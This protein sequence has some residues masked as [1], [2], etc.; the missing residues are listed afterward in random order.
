MRRRD[1]GKGIAGLVAAWP[2]SARAQQSAMPVIGFLSVAL[3]DGYRLRQALQGSGFIEGQN[4]AIE[5]RWIMKLSKRDLL[6]AAAVFAAAAGSPS[7]AQQPQK[8]Q[9][10]TSP[11][12][13]DSA[14]IRSGKPVK[15][16]SGQITS[17]P[18]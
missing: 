2:L 14:P 13:A 10:N 3:P 11:R 9:R 5:Y 17:P 12:R 16:G 4:V 7:F 6:G 1:F 8:P 18:A 15:S